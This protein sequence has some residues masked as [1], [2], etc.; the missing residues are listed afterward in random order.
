MRSGAGA[1]ASQSS[2]TAG[3]GAVA[4]ADTVAVKGAA[5]TSHATAAAA[6]SAGVAPA[7]RALRAAVS[8][9]TKKEPQTKTGLGLIVTTCVLVSR[10]I[11]VEI[12][13]CSLL[14][15]YSLVVERF[16]LLYIVLLSVFNQCSFVACT[17]LCD[18]A[19]D[20]S[21]RSFFVSFCMRMI[22]LPEFLVDGKSVKRCVSIFE[23]LLLI[24]HS[25]SPQPRNSS[26]NWLR[27]I[28]SQPAQHANRE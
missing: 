7:V 17:L 28:R 14:N 16:E 18:F 11:S 24:Q 5:A 20:S 1:V 19:F 2:S 25:P 4:A 27:P 12:Q 26:A 22:V 8:Q 21:M 23:L 3:V 9:P 10:H 13:L 6:D 15:F